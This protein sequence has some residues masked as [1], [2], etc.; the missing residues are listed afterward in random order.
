MKPLVRPRLR[1][2]DVI[3]VY[4]TEMGQEGVDWLNQAHDRDKWEAVMK[5]VMKCKVV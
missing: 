1:M 3:N 2:G 5:M 4:C